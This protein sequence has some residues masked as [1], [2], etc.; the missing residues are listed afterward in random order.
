MVCPR[1]ETTAGDGVIPN[2]CL[3]GTKGSFILRCDSFTPRASIMTAQE[4]WF[5]D[6]NIWHKSLQVRINLNPQNIQDKP[7]VM[8]VASWFL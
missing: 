4:A 2:Y 1:H 8:V 6:Q 3:L 5:K 7:V